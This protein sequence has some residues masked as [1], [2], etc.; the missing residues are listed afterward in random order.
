MTDDN[1]IKFIK[2]VDANGDG[3]ISYEEFKNM[4]KKLI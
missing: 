2:E 1:W 4:M 3:K